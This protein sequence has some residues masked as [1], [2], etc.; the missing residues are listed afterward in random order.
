MHVK[1]KPG[2]TIPDP[3]LHDLLPDDG[4][5][6]PETAYWMS[7]LRDGDVVPADPQQ[8]TGA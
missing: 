1:P 6:V 5:D 2:L 8:P 7:R 3:D 4:R